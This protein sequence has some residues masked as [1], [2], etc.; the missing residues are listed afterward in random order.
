MNRLFLAAAMIFSLSFV[1]APVASAQ[2]F[3]KVSASKFESRTPMKGYRFDRVSPLTAYGAEA[4]PEGVDE[5]VYRSEDGTR[6]LRGILD[7]RDKRAKW[8]MQPHFET[9]SYFGPGLLA[10]KAVNS[11]DRSYCIL[12]IDSDKCAPTKY[13]SIAALSYR[14]FQHLPEWVNRSALYNPTDTFNLVDL[15][16]VDDEG[17][18]VAEIP[19]AMRGRLGAHSDTT[20][21]Y[22]FGDALVVRTRP[23]EGVIEDVVLQRGEQGDVTQTIVPPFSILEYSDR[24]RPVKN[25]AFDYDAPMISYEKLELMFTANP[26][27]NLVWP[28][29]E[30]ESGFRLAPQ[31][32][33]GLMPLHFGF[34]DPQKH[35]RKYGDA[36]S[37]SH[38]CCD[39]P[40]GWLVAWDTPDGVRHALLRQKRVP[41]FDEV[42]A[43]RSQSDYLKFERLW[44]PGRDDRKSSEARAE[45]QLIGKYAFH[46]EDGTVEVF[47]G[48]IYGLNDGTTMKLE[49]SLPSSSYA[50]WTVQAMQA[51]AA[52]FAEAQRVSAE[53]KQQT[54]EHNRR[55]DAAWAAARQRAENI[56][57]AR[58]VAAQE[59]RAT[60]AQQRAAIESEIARR[61]AEYQSEYDAEV[62]R[63]EAWSA[64]RSS[65]NPGNSPNRIA[66]VDYWKS[67]DRSNTTGQYTTSSGA[68][69]GCRLG[70]SSC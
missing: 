69:T 54:E 56:N 18:P 12:A 43:S 48:D 51:G 7:R 22:A 64:W 53:I 38:F 45:G 15:L 20:K 2:S 46:R 34:S 58:A 5:I 11:Q 60:Q 19:N 25:G 40:L 49:I 28:N 65:L 13:T 23:A 6:R 37:M 63:Y 36:G 17:A 39:I 42:I 68:A 52:Q 57:A 47:R 14:D 70:A 16:I 61:E 32:M 66:Q 31:D 3:K 67:Y 24:H 59:N 29:Y 4:F 30:T 9:I 41:T 55:M 1:I 8:L 21:T 10:V 62:V 33:L 26:Q 27:L 44:R 50:D 35:T